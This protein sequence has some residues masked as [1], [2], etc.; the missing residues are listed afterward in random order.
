MLKGAL[1]K[2]ARLAAA[3]C[4]P[5]SSSLKGCRPVSKS[6][7]HRASSSLATTPSLSDTNS[8]PADTEAKLEVGQSSGTSQSSEAI[9]SSGRAARQR[10][11]VDNSSVIQK[12]VKKADKRS[13][14]LIVEGQTDLPP[15]EIA[16]QLQRQF[17]AFGEV[18]SLD[19]E[20][21]T[22]QPTT[23]AVNYFKKN[24]LIVGLSEMAL[25]YS[26]WIKRLKPSRGLYFKPMPATRAELH[27]ALNKYWPY[28]NNVIAGTREEFITAGTML[29][30]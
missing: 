1:S 25:Q 18:L 3:S 9:A 12:D 10:G 8:S 23:A 5:Y 16:E 27:K 14:T 30:K 15:E 26:P 19:V 29:T 6:N 13:N 20:F 11:S 22:Q 24:P 2:Q 17:S 28:I 21:E 4:R 7:I